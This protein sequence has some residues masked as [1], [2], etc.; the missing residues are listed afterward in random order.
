MGLRIKNALGMVPI[1]RIHSTVDDPASSTVIVGVAPPSLEDVISG[2]SC[3]QP[4]DLKSFTVFAKR[5]LFVETLLFLGE[6]RGLCVR[7]F[8][9]SLLRKEK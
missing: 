6:V 9:V 4:F 3:E 7:L 5:N 2:A 8:F 1:S